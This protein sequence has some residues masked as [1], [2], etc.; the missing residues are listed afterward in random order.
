[1]Y[2]INA[3]LFSLSCHMFYIKP[4]GYI[5]VSV[6][7]VLTSQK[8]LAKKQWLYPVVNSHANITEYKSKQHHSYYL[9]TLLI[10][11]DTNSTTSLQLAP[12]EII[13]I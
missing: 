7:F 6:L 3:E 2:N 4:Q 12:G 13:P 8:M 9:S 11:E 5:L 10:V 1:M